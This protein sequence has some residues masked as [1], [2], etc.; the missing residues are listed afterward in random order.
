MSGT[1]VWFTGLPSSGKSTLARRVQAELKARGTATC[2]LDGDEVRQAIVPPHAYDEV[3]R[4]H[5]YETL[6]NLAGLLARQ[7]LVVLVPATAHRDA[8]RQVARQRAPRFLLVWLDVPLDECVARDAKGLYQA[9]QRG[10]AH[11]LPGIGS[12][13]EPP[14]APDIVCRRGH[15]DGAVAELLNALSAAPAG[16][17]D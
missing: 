3:S 2:L 8:F 11:S 15:E 13:F 14:S 1:V 5:F 12:E 4:S 16:S 9:S 7:D 17:P 6:A 10:H